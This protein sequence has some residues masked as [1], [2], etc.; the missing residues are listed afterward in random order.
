LAILPKLKAFFLQ[1]YPKIGKISVFLPILGIFGA[2]KTGTFR[3]NNRQFNA[4]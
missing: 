4:E 3:K 1:K 2:G